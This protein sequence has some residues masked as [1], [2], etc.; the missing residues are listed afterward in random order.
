MPISQINLDANVMPAQARDMLGIDPDRIS[1]WRNRGVILCRG[2]IGRHELYRI[3]D[4]IE[5]NTKADADVRSKSH[6]D[7]VTA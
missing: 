2:K 6:R 7:P 5:L 3:G 4:L 1:R